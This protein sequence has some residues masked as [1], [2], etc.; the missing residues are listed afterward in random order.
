MKP[1]YG[2]EMLV[3]LASKTP[4]FS[5]QLPRV[6]TERQFLTELRKTLIATSDASPLG[7]IV[8]ASFDTIVTRSD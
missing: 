7:R 8:S 2:R 6:E 3:V 1:P 4:V 5:E